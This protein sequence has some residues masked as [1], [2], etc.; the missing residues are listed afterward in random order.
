MESCI[1]L[2]LQLGKGRGVLDAFR[3][4]GSTIRRIRAFGISSFVLPVIV[5]LFSTNRIV[6]RVALHDRVLRFTLVHSVTSSQ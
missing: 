2:G 1:T 6:S 3:T 4:G 5:C